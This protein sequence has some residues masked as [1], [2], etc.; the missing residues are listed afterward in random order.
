[1]LARDDFGGGEALAGRRLVAPGPPS[2]RVAGRFPFCPSALPRDVAARQRLEAATLLPPRRAFSFGTGGRAGD[3]P[4]GRS[5]RP[6]CLPLKR[7]A[8][9]VIAAARNHRTLRTEKPHKHWFPSARFRASPRR[10]RSTARPFLSDL[11]G[12]IAPDPPAARPSRVV[13]RRPK[14]YQP[15][16][17]TRRVMHVSTLRIYRGSGLDLAPYWISSERAAHDPN[18]QGPV[19]RL[20]VTGGRYACRRP[21]VRRLVRG[22]PASAAIRF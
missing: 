1:M 11:L 9:A 8:N 3:K 21:P 4:V 17:K 5:L 12:V 15:M 20:A 6:P 14:V 22:F 16:T 10:G 13:K 2:W 18:P 19:F 7:P